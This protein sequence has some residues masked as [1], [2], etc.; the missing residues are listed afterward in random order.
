MSYSIFDLYGDEL[1]TT[2]N[3]NTMK[4]AVEEA[5]KNNINLNF[6]NLHFGF[7]LPSIV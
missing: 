7:E 6:A 5:V 2:T 1:Y 3:A 4:K